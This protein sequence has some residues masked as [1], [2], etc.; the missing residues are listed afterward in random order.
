MI[1]AWRP[2]LQAAPVPRAVCLSASSR[3]CICWAKDSHERVNESGQKYYKCF[4]KSVCS[5]VTLWCKGSHTTPLGAWRP[6]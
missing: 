2:R 6:R 5:S 4:F 3:V 1:L